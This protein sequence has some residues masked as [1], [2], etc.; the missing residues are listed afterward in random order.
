MTTLNESI[1]SMRWVKIANNFM[2]SEQ[3]LSEDPPHISLMLCDQYNEP[4]YKRL[5]SYQTDDLTPAQ[6]AY[7]DY[8]NEL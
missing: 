4:V 2:S 5:I 3:I 7:E 8:M 1:M 6:R